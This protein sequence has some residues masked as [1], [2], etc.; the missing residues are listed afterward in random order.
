MSVNIWQMF[1]YSPFQNQRITWRES[2]EPLGRATLGTLA[3]EKRQARQGLW[4]AQP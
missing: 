1:F 3:H 4:P 2:R